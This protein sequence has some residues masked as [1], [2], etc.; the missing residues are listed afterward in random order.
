MRP[1][2][3]ERDKEKMRRSEAR[4]TGFLAPTREKAE[5]TEN[6]PIGSE[7]R[8]GVR[9]ATE[10]NYYVRVARRMVDMPTL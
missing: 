5:Q 7:V 1:Q 8:F 6:A 4:R 9:V 2:S 10:Q 3:G